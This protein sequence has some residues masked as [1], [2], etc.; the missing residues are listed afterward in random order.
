MN[1]TTDDKERIGKGF[2]AYIRE[3]SEDAQRNVGDYREYA[4]VEINEV[5]D[6]A[7]KMEVE[8]I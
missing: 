6:L 1:L 2:A 7:S 4:L 5:R 8:I 3:L